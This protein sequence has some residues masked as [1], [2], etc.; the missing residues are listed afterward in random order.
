[1]SRTNADRAY[2]ARRCLD[3]FAELTGEDGLNSNIIDLITNLGHVCDGHQVDF[4]QMVV[5]AVGH[6]KF[7]Q[8]NDPEGLTPLVTIQ[9]HDDESQSQ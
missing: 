2:D 4:L 8:A 5:I 6:W 1:M 3:L 9:I 7:E